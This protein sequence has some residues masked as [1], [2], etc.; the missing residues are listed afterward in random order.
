[1]SARR[2]RA[3]TGMTGRTNIDDNALS[4]RGQQSA[5]SARLQEVSTVDFPQVT[6]S[7]TTASANEVPVPRL[8]Q[9]PFFLGLSLIIAEIDTT[10]EHSSMSIQLQL[11]RSSCILVACSQYC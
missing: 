4:A 8:Q 2:E 6:L 9:F 1:M 10:D 5:R 11:L 7:S 3:P